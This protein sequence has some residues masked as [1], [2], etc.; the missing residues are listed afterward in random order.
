MQME[1]LLCLMLLQ[2][3]HIK[4]CLFGIITYKKFHQIFQLLWLEIR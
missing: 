3:S 2:E 1:L 4:V